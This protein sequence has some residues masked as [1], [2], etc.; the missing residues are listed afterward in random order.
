MFRFLPMLA[1]ISLI[2]FTIACGATADLAETDISGNP[3][4]TDILIG[5]V[6]ATPEGT[7]AR[8]L[9]LAEAGEWEVYVDDYYGEAYKF[10]DDGDRTSLV[11]RFR[12]DW[13]EQ[14]ID[15][16][17]KAKDVSPQLS[18][19]GLEAVFEMEGGTFILYNDGNGGWKFHL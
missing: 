9:Q 3:G 1:G 5:D 14:V 18:S 4:T 12:E 11:T 16:L 2:L 15:A 17:R 6:P 13:S 8:L 10:N 19:D 7:V